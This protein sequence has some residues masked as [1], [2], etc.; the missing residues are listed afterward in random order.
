MKTGMEKGNEKKTDR[1]RKHD[2]YYETD[3]AAAAADW[4]LPSHAGSSR[5]MAAASD[6]W[7]LL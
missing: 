6:C 1:G 3:N 7:N 2:I 4:A 5:P